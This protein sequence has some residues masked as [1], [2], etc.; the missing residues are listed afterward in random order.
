MDSKIPPLT[1]KMGSTLP[2]R[3]KTRLRVLCDM[4]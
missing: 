3:L 2:M 1:Q 4:R